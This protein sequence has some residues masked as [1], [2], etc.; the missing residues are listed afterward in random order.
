MD[1]DHEWKKL[2]D[3]DADEWRAYR[4][5][6]EYRKWLKEFDE[7][8]YKKLRRTY[9][10]YPYI[11]KY[12]FSWHKNNKNR[13][14]VPVNHLSRFRTITITYEL[15]DKTTPDLLLQAFGS[16]VNLFPDIK[17]L[18]VHSE[19]TKDPLGKVIEEEN[20]NED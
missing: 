5:T 10:D 6:P 13:E 14:E 9:L 19:Y 4:D 18:T 8:A 11:E 17:V 2:T 12:I 7:K 20:K 16:N 3:F 1:T 15:K